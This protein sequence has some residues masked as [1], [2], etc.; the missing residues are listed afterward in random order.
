M[1]SRILSKQ[2]GVLRQ[3]EGER[4]I[5]GNWVRSPDGRNRGGESVRCVGSGR[6]SQGPLPRE[7]ESF[8]LCET[9]IGSSWGS[10]EEL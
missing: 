10:K 4:Q 8:L 1:S 5:V 2:L 9:A 3:G 7:P 6:S